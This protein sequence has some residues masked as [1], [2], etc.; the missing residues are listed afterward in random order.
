MM[1]KGEFVVYLHIMNYVLSIIQILS[2]K[3]QMKNETLGK[4]ANTV[5]GV[6]KTFE[7]SRNSES[8]SNLWEEIENFS[9]ENCIDLQIPTRRMLLF[10]LYH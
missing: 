6:I 3:L 5:I 7:D 8:F 2:C 4:A 9:I 10:T 1:L